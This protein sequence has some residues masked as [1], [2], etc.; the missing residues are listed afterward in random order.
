LSSALLTAVT[1]MFRPIAFAADQVPP[2]YGPILRK[3]FTSSMAYASADPDAEIGLL[4]HD[5]MLG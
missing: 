3:W 5:V 1:V 2:W 4:A